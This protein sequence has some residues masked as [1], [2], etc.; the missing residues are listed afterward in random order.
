MP[1][2]GEHGPLYPDREHR[3]YDWR[4][5][6][7]EAMDTTSGVS[8]LTGG[9]CSRE[10]YDEYQSA[11]EELRGVGWVAWSDH[12]PTTNNLFDVSVDPRIRDMMNPEWDKIQEDMEAF[13]ADRSPEYREGLR[14]AFLA[15]IRKK[16]A[17]LLAGSEKG[18]E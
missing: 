5:V 15:A 16:E 9:N 13:Y 2:F 18:A 11:E 7:G 14:K 12:P 8:G 4:D 10:E 1:T 6:E 17:E 3:V